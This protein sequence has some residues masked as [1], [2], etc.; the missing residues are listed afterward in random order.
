[1]LWIILRVRNNRW[2]TPVL[3]WR[4]EKK[5]EDQEYSGKGNGKDEAEESNVSRRSKPTNM[6]KG[7]RELVNGVTLEKCWKYVGSIHSENKSI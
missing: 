5:E 1:M 4:A 7:D 6:V 2:S 3:T